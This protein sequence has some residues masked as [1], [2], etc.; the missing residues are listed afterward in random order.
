M[1]LAAWVIRTHAAS[2]M[3]FPAAI[4]RS[5]ELPC[6]AR[7]NGSAADHQRPRE[8]Q[9]DPAGVGAKVR[10]RGGEDPRLHFSF[11][12]TISG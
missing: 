12:P 3:G 1:L 2:S 7:E 10:P 5:A 11:P 6:D 8:E 9:V 4:H